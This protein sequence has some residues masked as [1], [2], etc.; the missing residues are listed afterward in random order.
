MLKLGE[1][2]SNPHRDRNFLNVSLY[3]FF[4][5]FSVVVFNK[6]VISLS[7]SLHKYLVENRN[8]FVV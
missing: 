7:L 1:N 2:L 8:Q 5:N 6:P 3:S 4:S